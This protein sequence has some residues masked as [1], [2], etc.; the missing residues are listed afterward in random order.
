M[1]YTVDNELNDFSGVWDA[2][3]GLYK[4]KDDSYVRI[5]T[6]F[7]QY[8]VSLVSNQLFIIIIV[9]LVTVK[10]FWIFSNANQREN[11]FKM[12]YCIGI[13]SIL[14]QKAQLEIC[15]RPR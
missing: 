5:H 6:N 13:L 4:T 3:A 10:E 12:L 7:P 9:F 15:V 2:I 14:R 1:W 8:I 11:Q